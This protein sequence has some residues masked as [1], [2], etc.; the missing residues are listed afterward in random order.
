M[1]ELS[2]SSAA[3]L[4]PLYGG[5][6][7]RYAR[8]G[9]GGGYR[10]ALIFIELPSP[11]FAERRVAERVQAGGH[12]IPVSDIHRRFK[13]GLALFEQV[14]KPMVDVLYHWRS[15]EKGLRLVHQS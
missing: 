6:A 15:D 3:S 1:G 12:A 8:G 4:L 9:G 5:G 2:A 14:Y 10:V 13:R 7:P 11:A